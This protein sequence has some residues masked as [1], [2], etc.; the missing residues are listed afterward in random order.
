MPPKMNS[1]KQNSFRSISDSCPIRTSSEITRVSGMRHLTQPKERYEM[2]YISRGRRG[3]IT[4]LHTVTI[5]VLFV[6]TSLVFK[7]WAADENHQAE[8]DLARTQAYYVA[9]KGIFER[10]MFEMRTRPVETLPTGYTTYDGG[11]MKDDAGYL[12]GS[13]TKPY[14]NRVNNI[15][16][17]SV[18]ST[19]FF[20][21]LG[22]TGSVSFVAYDGEVKTV[23]RK[24][25]MLAKL[26]TY[27]SY[28]YLTHYEMTE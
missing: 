3:S 18:F 11:T 13:Y 26:R 8:F 5:V 19:T 12:V 14:I 10:P 28:M 23:S 20:Y 27:A 22:A 16:S 21:E 24:V 6:M 2:K 1:C 7:K 4:L 15:S 9:Q 17:Q 25:T